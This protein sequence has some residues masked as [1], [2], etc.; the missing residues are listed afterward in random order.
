MNS[1][2]KATLLSALLIF[3]IGSIAYSQ[4]VG[5]LIN[6]P[7]SWQG[8]TL[9]SPLSD[10]STYLINNCG[11]LINKWETGYIPGNH[12]RLDEN[13]NLYR[14]GETN[15]SYISAGGAGGIIEQYDW[16]N[17]LIW[18]YEV[19]DSIQRMHHDFE[20]MPNGH[21]LAIVWEKVD[22]SICIL[23]GKDP[24]LLTSGESWID[25]IIELEPVGTDSANIVWE[26]SAFNHIVQAFD[27]SKAN[28]G[29][30]STSPRLLNFNAGNNQSDWL[31]CNGIDYN[32]EKD[33]IALSSPDM[34]EVY[35]I[36][37]STTTLE[38]ASGA[39]GNYGFGGDFLYRWGNPMRYE[40]GTG[41]DQKLFYQHDVHWIKK[42]LPDAGKI[43]VFNNRLFNGTDNSQ[44]FILLI[45]TQVVQVTLS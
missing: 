25:K 45:Q 15:N 4:T 11:E 41:A 36:D 6:S 7:S 9:L 34:N 17:N 13:G 5:T 42:G 22:A 32:A 18:S 23:A 35:F 43:M 28:F 39:G 19:S 8:Y 20:V 24:L 14:A 10:S 30:I 40:Q 33:I 38:A 1:Y 2:F 27:A 3:S 16:D 31:H 29:S 12:A 21:I 37:H 44:P 26:W